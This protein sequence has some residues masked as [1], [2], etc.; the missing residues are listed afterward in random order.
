MMN[1]LFRTLIPAA[2]VQVRGVSREEKEIFAAYLVDL[3]EAYL[4]NRQA[5]FAALLDKFTFPADVQ[6]QIV[7]AL[8]TQ[9]H[10]PVER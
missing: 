5:D 4:E 9:E 1:G 7:L 3:C 6:K 2:L 8:W 10:Y